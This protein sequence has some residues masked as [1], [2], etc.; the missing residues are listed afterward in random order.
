[1]NLKMPWIWQSRQV[2]N[3]HKYTIFSS[4]SKHYTKTLFTGQA[5]ADHNELHT[6]MNG[7]S[8]PGTSL[9]EWFCSGGKSIRYWSKNIFLWYCH[10]VSMETV[11]SSFVFFTHFGKLREKRMCCT[12]IRQLLVA[13]HTYELLCVFYI[14]S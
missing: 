6:V 10:G 5:N 14:L 7:L 9:I 3:I 13:V 11:S 2:W 4:I 12:W 1:M 8:I